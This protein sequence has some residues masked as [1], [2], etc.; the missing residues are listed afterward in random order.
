M[1]TGL[2]VALSCIV[3]LSGC[4][5]TRE[6]DLSSKHTF[7]PGPLKVHPGLLG[8]AAPAPAPV[9]VPPVAAVAQAAPAPA[10]TA[11]P[12]P[13][14]ASAPSASGM[15]KDLT[16]HLRSE[17]S[18]YFDLNK[19]ELKADYDPVL[20]AHAQ[21]LADNPGAKVRLEGHADE[22]GSREYNRQL[23]LKR[24]ETVRS[25]LLERGAPE[26]QLAIKSY[27]ELKPRLKGHDEESWAENRRADVIYE[28]E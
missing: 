9:V 6:K 13:E 8:M 26:K 11:A 4:A 20:K 10:V 2:S 22:R 7:E 15:S 25:A 28:S 14:P 21:Y 3:L 27:G 24:A 5:G 16:A 23:G 17:R 12:T 19:S 1:R 18:F